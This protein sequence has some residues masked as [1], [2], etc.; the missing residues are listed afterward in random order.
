[1][2]SFLERLLILA[3][4]G[5]GSTLPF[6]HARVPEP[7]APLYDTSAISR[8]ERNLA[9]VP[10]P[11][12]VPSERLHPP[13]RAPVSTTASSGQYQTTAAVSLRDVPES[14]EEDYLMIVE[15]TITV[16]LSK[17]IEVINDASVFFMSTKVQQKA[18]HPNNSKVSLL[19]I[20]ITALAVGGVISEVAL[21]EAVDKALGKKSKELEQLLRDAIAK[22]KASR[23][24][25][26]NVAEQHQQLSV[27]SET[28]SNT[29]I[30]AATAATASIFMIGCV[31][32]CL[33][34]VR[35]DSV[36]DDFGLSFQPDTV[37]QKPTGV[38]TS[39]SKSSL[40]EYDVESPSAGSMSSVKSIMTSRS[41]R[42]QSDHD[43]ESPS[44]RSI[45]SL[46]YDERMYAKSY[47]NGNVSCQ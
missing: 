16:F 4:V 20:Q 21:Q 12:P 34:M 31:I 42:T 45:I 33:F 37:K 26:N 10:A 24:D 32:A 9:D 8:E 25:S 29:V 46:P 13:T 2:P 23:S 28:V 18:Q 5:A 40:S 19:E 15:D 35:H 36:E 11:S 38:T 7:F 27:G 41:E 6:A 14:L 22:S 17:E 43:V 1:M 47:S 30:I 44:A 39:H 3:L